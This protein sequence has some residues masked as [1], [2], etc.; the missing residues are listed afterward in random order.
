MNTARILGGGLLAGLI[1]NIGEA[2]LHG[3]VLASATEQ[4]F[5]ALG[6]S[7][8]GDPLYLTILVAMTFAQGVLGVWL[9]AAIRP[10]FGSGPRTAV[11]AGLVVWALS[12]LY[13]AVYLHSGMATL[14]PNGVVWIPAAWGLVE[15]PL[16]TLAGA[17][18]YKEQ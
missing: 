14:L 9:Y 18:M 1:L 17:A 12:A 15:F 16:A 11:I 2:A 13:G 5:Q 8:P 7:I 3:G 10:R 4:A 6:R